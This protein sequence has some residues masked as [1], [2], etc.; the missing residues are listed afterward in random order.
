MIDRKLPMIYEHIINKSQYEFE[1]FGKRRKKSCLANHFFTTKK[2]QTSCLRGMADYM[3]T[4]QKVGIG[5]ANK[6]QTEPPSKRADGPGRR[7]H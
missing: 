3:Y 1:M 6:G 5:V 4:I 7:G 2:A